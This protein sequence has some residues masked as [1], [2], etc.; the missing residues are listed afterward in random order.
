MPI[1]P[2][3]IGECESEIFNGPLSPLTDMAEE[4]AVLSLRPEHVSPSPQ[5]AEES[6]DAT[7]IMAPPSYPPSLNPSK[8]HRGKR[9]SK[10][11][12]DQ[13]EEPESVDGK[14]SRTEMPRWK[15][16]NSSYTLVSHID[17]ADLEDREQVPIKLSDASE[18]F[19]ADIAERVVADEPATETE[20]QTGKIG[21]KVK[22]KGR[23]P[24]V[25]I[26]E[27]IHLIRHVLLDDGMF[28]K[29]EKVFKVSWPASTGADREIFWRILGHSCPA[30]VEDV[31]RV[32]DDIPADSKAPPKV[33]D[34]PPSTIPKPEILPIEYFRCLEKRRFSPQEYE[35]CEEQLATRPCLILSPRTR[36]E[37]DEAYEPPILD[38]D[39]I[40]SRLRIDVNLKQ[41]AHELD[42][43]TS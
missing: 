1:K 13:V 32:I 8:W 37:V 39:D 21:S 20:P 11:K 10:R 35:K 15:M 30:T 23:V 2:A 19:T 43:M 31:T 12:I 26:K 5:L 40:S 42:T 9:K 36:T 6:R 27:D 25:D 18:I 34:A 22:L 3:R 41:E 14:R 24:E 29:E 16:H 28:H 33:R 7:V 38:I 4:L 17:L